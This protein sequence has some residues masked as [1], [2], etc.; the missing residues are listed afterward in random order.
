[1]NITLERI[2]SRCEQAEEEIHQLKG[3]TTE[4]IESEGPTKK[5]E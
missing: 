3:K 1:M 5:N 4:I 2:N